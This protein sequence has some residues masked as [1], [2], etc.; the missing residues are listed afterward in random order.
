M[1]SYTV[2]PQYSPH[3]WEKSKSILYESVH[4]IEV[5]YTITLKLI[6]NHCRHTI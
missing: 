5:L 2:E 4:Y 1:V 6:V 3:N